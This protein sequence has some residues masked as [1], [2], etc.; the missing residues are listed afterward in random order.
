MNGDSPARSGR[1]LTIQTA[2]VVELGL[3]A[4]LTSVGVTGADVFEPALSVL[5]RRKAAGMAGTMQFTYRNPERSTDA[6][7]RLPEARALVV[8]AWAYPS[9]DEPAPDRPAA[10]VAR[11]ARSDHY[12]RLERAL[13]VVAERLGDH[14][15]RA[16]VLADTNHLVDRNVAWRAG[17]G[18]YGKNTNLLLPGQGSWFV[19]GSVLT[20]APLEPT[21][22]PET[23]GCG[24]CTKCLDD[25]PTGAIV[26]PGV[27]DATRC[28]AWL[29]QAGEPIPHR[30]RPAVG[31]RLYGC[32]DCQEVCPPN[33]VSR[34]DEVEITDRSPNGP[35]WLD[36]AW[37]LTASDDD[38][39]ARHGRWYI[40]DRNVDVI[41]R[42]ALVV[43]GNIA[44]PDDGEPAIALL[45][46]YLSHTNPMLRGHALWAVRRLGLDLHLEVDVVDDETTAIEQAAEVEARFPSDAWHHGDGVLPEAGP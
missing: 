12:R 8:G 34:P 5:P 3:G 29:V 11:Y 20:D 42:T 9:G 2:D 35:Q 22:P 26:A 6:T 46:R 44:R 36:V 32:D 39:L 7:R 33:Q 13:E 4:G 10:R 17:I 24:R 18:W 25:C 21:G 23:D 38:I 19:L 40:A 31:D 16:Q 45:R 28:I 43:L 15:Y 1:R 41:R 27:V 37:F 14:G 30:L